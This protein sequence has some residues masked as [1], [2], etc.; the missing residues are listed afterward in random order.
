MTQL[1]TSEQGQV[2]R[3]SQ[4]SFHTHKKKI[5]Y[6]QCKRM[7]WEKKGRCPAN[8]AEPFGGFRKTLNSLTATVEYLKNSRQQW[9]AVC[10]VICRWFMLSHYVVSD[11][12]ATPWT[13]AHQAPTVH[14]FS[15]TRILV[16]VAT[17]FSRASSWPRSQTHI[18]CRF[19]TTEPLGKPTQY[20]GTKT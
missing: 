2:L 11:S 1:E 7:L 3:T 18:S 15:Q 5:P 9:N 4:A 14:G 13:V 6:R 8:R 12:S 19:F 16:W 10:A 20:K 17:S